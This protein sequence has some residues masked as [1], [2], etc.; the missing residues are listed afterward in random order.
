MEKKKRNWKKIIVIAGLLVMPTLI[1]YFFVF[2]GVHHLARLPFYGPRK[3]EPKEYRGKTIMDTVY[4]EIPPFMLVR[5]DSTLLDSRKLDGQIYVAH[6]LDFAQ[7]DKI[8]DEVIYIAADVLQDFPEVYF[9]T[10]FEHYQGQELPPPS[11]FTSKLAGKDTSWIYVTGPQPTLDSLRTYGYF[12]EDNDLKV[13]KDPYS[14][15]LIDKEKRIRGYY[16]PILAADSK[17]VKDEISYLKREY[18]L[19]F[20]THR[21]YKYDDKIEKGKK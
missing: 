13:Q 21:Y 7:L 2:N 19:N 11:S 5:S 9:V 17:R 1:F 16:N 6:F 20:R 8:P 4:H 18:E 12:A 14:L 15:V 10:H 3:V